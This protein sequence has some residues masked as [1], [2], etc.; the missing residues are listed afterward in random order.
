M[1]N[2]EL[3]S[4]IRAGREDL[5]ALL[6]DQVRGFVADQAVK[7]YKAAIDLRSIDVD[8][9][10]Q[11][12]YF[13]LLQAVQYYDQAQEYKFTT[14]LGYCLKTAFSEACGFRT[15]KR[16]PILF[17]I[18][19]DAPINDDPDSDT[20]GDFIP[21]KRDHFESVDQKIYTEQ[22]RKAIERSAAKLTAAQRET[23]YRVF[24]KGETFE[25]IGR[26][27][28]VSPGRVRS[29]ER[30]AI[31]Q[32]RKPSA[33]I[34]QFVDERTPFYKAAGYEAFKRTGTSQVERLVM[35]REQIRRGID[36]EIWDN[37]IVDAAAQ[38]A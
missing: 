24:M 29:W 10:I 32:L 15:S 8:D 27:V 33:G 3:V 13:A 22:L 36:V 38:L 6:W 28:C 5:Y 34:I 31:R 26:F 20:I 4:E 9:L 1:T 7:Y 12:G 21:D 30:D 2:E 16:D 11:C 23:I 19:L 37:C 25:D 18:S 17:S 14:A 35:L